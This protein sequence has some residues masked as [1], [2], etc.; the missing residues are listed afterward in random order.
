MYNDTVTS[1][2]VPR[3]MGLSPEALTLEIEVT[4]YVLLVS[5]GMLIWDTVSNLGDDYRMLANLEWTLRKS[6][7][8]T[9]YIVSRL[10]A[11][12][13]LATGLIMGP[14]R[15]NLDCH[16]A[17]IFLEFFFFIVISTTTGLFALRVR[18]IFNGR[19]LIQ[20]AFLALW[21]GTAG[22][23]VLAFF[24]LGSSSNPDKSVSSCILVERKISLGL[25]IAV[26]AM[27]HDT[28]VFL[29]V[30][31]QMYHYHR[32]FGGNTSS[33]RRVKILVTNG[34]DL[35]PLMKSLLHD[36]Q[37]YYLISLFFEIVVVILLLVPGLGPYYR[38]FILPA[39]LVIV[40][41]IACL[42]FR[43]V[44]LGRYKKEAVYSNHSATTSSSLFSSDATLETVRF[45]SNG[46]TTNGTGLRSQELTEMA[47]LKSNDSVNSE[48]IQ[49][50][51]SIV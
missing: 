28:A 13:L 18:A 39:H 14:L 48:S 26:M 46:R 40:N 44:Q 47:N 7:S 4:I 12:G 8:I 11:L 3:D 30:S 35:P 9:V 6:I 51:T 2:L 27:V 50:G 29:G 31:Y 49:A 41:A 43:N 24:V 42:V 38:C 45:A 16:I 21:M 20:A 17:G 32:L 34:K 22:S 37:M 15:A 33:S 1:P 25:I 23:C 36:G 19:P 5:A 10:S